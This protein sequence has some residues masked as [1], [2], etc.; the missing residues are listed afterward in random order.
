ME[1]G[2]QHKKQVKDKQA[3]MAGFI[4]LNSH[5]HILGQYCYAKCKKKK[6]DY[7]S[8]HIL[9]VSTLRFSALIELVLEPTGLKKL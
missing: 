3:S 6:K 8:S 7:I 5:S 2:G 9:G 4:D 1:I